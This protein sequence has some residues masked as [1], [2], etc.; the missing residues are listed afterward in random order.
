M[1]SVEVLDAY[2]R[3]YRWVG[4]P[5]AVVYEFVDDQGGYLSALLACYGFVSLFPLLLLLVTVLGFVLH[6]DPAAQ[7][8]V[9][10]PALA[11]VP[12]LGEQLRADGSGLDGSTL[13]CSPGSSARSTAGRVWPRPARTP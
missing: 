1:P 13:R 3:P 12:V 8:R 4:L 6:G 7:A 10:D 9:L 5:L 11:Q 2:Q